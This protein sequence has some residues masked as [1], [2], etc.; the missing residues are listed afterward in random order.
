MRQKLI[1][2]AMGV[3]LVGLAAVGA[4]ASQD[5]VHVQSETPTATSTAHPGA[6][7]TPK[8]EKTR[9]DDADTPDATDADAADSDAN[10]GTPRAVKGIPTTNPSHHPDDGDGICEKGETAI[11]T[12]PSGVQVN[13]PCHAA[14]HTNNGKHT[15]QHGTPEA[16]ETETPDD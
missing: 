15:G 5:A 8:A 12:T 3:A 2:T 13:V 14:D 6:A 9:P 1:A 16:D 10:D 11:K 4:F 7:H